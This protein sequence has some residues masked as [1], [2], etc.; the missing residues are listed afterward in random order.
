LLVDTVTKDILHRAAL[1]HLTAR[2][3]ADTPLRLVGAANWLILVT[4]LGAMLFAAVWI[5]RVQAPVTVSGQGILMSRAGLVEIGRNAG[6]VIAVGTPLATLAPVAG[7]DLVGVLYVPPG[8]GK[9]ITVGMAARVIPA[10]VE[11]EVY[12]HLVGTVEA[13]APQPATT[14]S[15]R[16][17]LR[18]DR[19][20]AQLSSTGA[21][22]EVRIALQRRESG[23]RIVW[24]VSDGP[25]GGISGGTLVAGEIVVDEVPVL[26]LIVPGATARLERL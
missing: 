1:A 4:F 22:I 11:P 24:S 21:P 17:T 8:V 12:G 18:N 9:R 19:L 2:E 3:E 5:A 13:V 20:V 25:E 23:D 6:D 26:D 16:R 7:D 10:A 15:M 14:E